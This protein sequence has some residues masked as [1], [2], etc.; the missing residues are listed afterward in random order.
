MNYIVRYWVEGF[1]GQKEYF[2]T[3]EEAEYFIDNKI[4]KYAED[5]EIIKVKEV[6]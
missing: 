3:Y 6:K 2:R 5:I 4:T 1:G